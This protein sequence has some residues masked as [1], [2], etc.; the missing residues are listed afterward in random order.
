MITT[1]LPGT[2]YDAEALA[3]HE[4]LVLSGQLRRNL[5][6]SNLDLQTRANLEAIQVDVTRALDA[7][8][9]VE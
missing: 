9:V 7:R 1:P 5:A 8:Q 6:K 4:L 3:H 2:P